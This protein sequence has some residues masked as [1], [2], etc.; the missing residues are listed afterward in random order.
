LG[1]KGLACR[2]LKI[3]LTEWFEDLHMGAVNQPLN[4]RKTRLSEEFVRDDQSF[5]SAWQLD[6]LKRAIWIE[7][8]Y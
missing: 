5:L 6:N 4:V 3:D 8:S 1:E 7:Q 2:S